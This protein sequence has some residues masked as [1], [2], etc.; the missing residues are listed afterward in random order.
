MGRAVFLIICLLVVPALES[1]AQRTDD[2]PSRVY[3]EQLTPEA[4][5]E[6]VLRSYLIPSSVS[7]ESNGVR[8]ARSQFHVTEAGDA[9]FV[10]PAVLDTTLDLIV[11][12]N[13]IP[14]RVGPVFTLIDTTT[15]YE[16]ERPARP[17]PAIPPPTAA[18]DPFAGVSLQRRGSVTR[19]ITTGSNRDV[20]V[21]SGLRLELSGEVAEGVGIRA[22]LSDENTPILPEGTTRRVEEFDQVFIEIQSPVGTAQLG[23][24]DY[25]LRGTS[26]ANFSR[27]LQGAAVR[28]RLSTDSPVLSSASVNAAGATSRG[29][30]RSQVIT[31]TDGVQGPYRLHGSAGEQF[32]LVIPG[33][34]RVFW[35]GLLL[36]RGEAYD[37]TLDY[38][39]GELHFTTN[40]IVTSERRVLVEF[41]YSTN[42]FTRTLLATQLEGEFWRGAHGPR[43]RIGGAFIREADGSR[44]LEEFGLTAEDSLLLAEAGNAPAFRSGAERVEF[45]PEA[46]FVQYVQR[47]TILA[48]GSTEQYF[49]MVG[50]RPSDDVAVYR[51]AFTHVGA[52]NGSYDRVGHSVNGIAYEY[53]GPDSGAYAPIRHLP[54]PSEKYVMDVYGSVAILPGLEAFGEW[55]HSIHDQNRLSSIDQHDNEGSAFE[56]GLRLQP[57]D[58]GAGVQL[59]GLLQRRRIDERF[60]PFDRIRPVEFGRHWNL[61]RG[62]T[63]AEIILGGFETT[64]E[65][66]LQVTHERIGEATGEIGRLTIGDWFSGARQ[67][68]SLQGSAPGWPRLEYYGEHIRSKNMT[69]LER[70]RWHRHGGSIHVPLLSGRFT[71]GL[72]AEYE[73]RRQTDIAA[74][75]LTHTSFRFAQITPEL[76]WT[77]NRLRASTELSIRRDDEWIDGTI[78]H[79]YDSWTTSVGAEYTGDVLNSELRLGYRE[80]RISELFRA[81]EGRV[82]H[83]SLLIRSGLR[84]RPHPRAVDITTSYEATSERTPLLQEI[85]VRT[86]PELGEYVWED[87]NGDGIIQVD[88]MLPQR[89]PNE[90]I[91]AR[92]YIP[93]D[94]LISTV[95]VRARAEARLDGAAVWREYDGWRGVLGNMVSR[96]IF[97]VSE[98]TR[99]SDLTRI[100]LLYLTRYR[101]PLNTINGRLRLGQN[102]TLW[103]HS[104]R[105][106]LDLGYNQSRSLSTRT[107]GG[108]SRFIA[109]W[110]KESRWSITDRITL[111]TH[112]IRERNRQSSEQFATRRFDITGYR[113]EPEP[114]LRITDRIRISLPAAFAWKDDAEAERRATVLRLPLEF[115]FQIP[116]RLVWTSRFETAHVSVVGESRGLAEFELTDGRGPGTSFL[117]TSSAR[118]NVN[119]Y[120][121]A[122]LQYDGRAPENA[123]VI[124]SLRMQLSAVF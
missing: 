118:Y 93:S 77:D 4:G 115:Q 44:F 105:F 102:V 22:M 14:L 21:D 122:T 119:E 107:V 99:D 117:W 13:T 56:V 20:G 47:D 43:I 31:L 76:M 23:D 79:A 86:G 120:L 89:T 98:T 67:A 83:S 80:R 103:P 19:G 113:V 42:Q 62:P 32:V 70:G 74:D 41:E 54:A 46:P 96:S 92:T 63:E 38:A 60:S 48:D 5:P 11:W 97:E 65:A 33:T 61:D 28:S 124:H 108:E 39:T 2:V 40:R 90:G 112:L 18:S 34:E 27:K 51:V 84:W 100:Y 45:D 58:V 10:E 106:T 6:F 116:S 9:L 69:I 17:S 50:T 52:G 114:S 95:T 111:R 53:R 88:E 82:D 3:R 72:R 8:L 30:F 121:R 94:S 12:Y 7:V 24:I 55:A 25:R 37:Y 73:D 1:V 64:D 104:R 29:Q 81:Q 78:A 101:N 57:A 36:E 109:T 59:S 85:F 123:P 110:T 26:F 15:A 75:R 71:P 87:L 66:R 68:V 91:Y 16:V 35:D 49:K